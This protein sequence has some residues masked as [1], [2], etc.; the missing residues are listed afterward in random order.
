MATS[1]NRFKTTIKISG[2]PV[3][4]SFKEYIRR[5][6]ADYINWEVWSEYYETIDGLCDEVLERLAKKERFS[7]D[8]YSDVHGVRYFYYDILRTLV[9]RVVPLQKRGYS[10]TKI[11]KKLMKQQIRVE[12]NLETWIRMLYDYNTIRKVVKAILDT[13]EQEKLKP[14]RGKKPERQYPI[15]KLRQMRES[16]MSIRKISEETG[17]SKSTVHRLLSQK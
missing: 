1:R 14:K 16:G 12:G 3:G 5:K 10:R 13:M 7:I 15:E 6:I 17:I 2:T 4:Q 9:Q 8:A 11:W